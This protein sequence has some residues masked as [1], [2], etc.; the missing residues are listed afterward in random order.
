MASDADPSNVPLHIWAIDN[1]S[2]EEARQ[3]QEL[4]KRRCWPGGFAD[5][6]ERS[7]LPWLRRWRATAGIPVL[8]A[9]DCASGRCAT[10]N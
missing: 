9:C 8:T 4:L 3:V 6:L 10:C 2:E 1:R 7:A 5:R